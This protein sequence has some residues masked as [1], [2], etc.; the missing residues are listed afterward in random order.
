MASNWN[1]GDIWEICA[2]ERDGADALVFGD[3]RRSWSQFDRR[4]GGIARTLLDAGLEHQDKF[5]QYLYNCPEYLE[6]VFAATKASLVPVNTNYRYEDRELGYLWDNADV[7]A[8]VFHGSFAERVSRLRPALPKV[9][10]WLHVDDGTGDCPDFA[11]RYEQAASCIGDDGDPRVIGGRGRSGDD[12][13]FLYTGGTT[14]MPKGVMWR[15]DDLFALLNAGSVYSHPVDEG[16]EGIRTSLRSLAGTPSVLLPA[17]P[18][19]HGTGSFTSFAALALGGVVVLLPSRHF[20]PVEL[21]DT[22]VREGVNLVTLVGDAFA[23]PI[24][25]AL[26]AEP[27]RWDLSSVLGMISSGVMWSEETKHGLLAHQ[28]TMMLIDSFGSSEALGMGS[29]VSASGAEAHTAT[30]RL[31]PNAKVVDDEGN[32]CEPGSG[33]VGRLAVGGRIPLGYYKDEA[34]TLSTFVTLGGAR[35]SV[36]GDFATVEADGTLRLLG[37]GSVCINTGGEKVY[38]EEVE[39]ILKTHAAVA[40]AACVGIPNERF[41]EEIAAVVEL[42]PPGSADP[43]AL[44]AHVKRRLAHYKAPRHVV[45]VPS[46]GRTP[47]G[48]LDYASLRRLAAD[49]LAEKAPK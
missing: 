43:D 38:P 46:L 26:D 16:L 15:Q 42:L 19:M 4:A 20:D 6:S 29:S 44:I 24:L 10:I 12:L 41:G 8:V 5:A 30:F 9:K 49:E 1:L 13:Y 31:G 3:L 32:E 7:A 25:A 33:K 34:K 37:R 40:D 35:Y 17:C 36:P 18:L 27:D 47:A 2:D 28:P 23:K 21:L 39:E 45:F 14:G 11:L 22:V 48:K